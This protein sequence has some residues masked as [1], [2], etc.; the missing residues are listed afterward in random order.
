MSESND[1]KNDSW[2]D[3]E[4]G[5]GAYAFVIGVVVLIFLMA[6][7]LIG[8]VLLNQPE[9]QDVVFEGKQSASTAGETAETGETGEAETEETAPAAPPPLAVLPEVPFPPDNPYS[10]EKAE[11]GKILFFDPRFSGDGSISCNSCHPASDGSWTVGSPISFGY[12]GSTHW[13]NASTIIN[14]AYYTKV[15]WDGGKTSL[16]KQAAGAWGGAVAGNMDSALAEERMA[17]IPGY[18]DLF[19]EVFGTERP[20]WDQALL[21]VGTFERTIVSENV[22]FDAF[23]EGDES[24]ISDD[25][26]AGY[27]LFTGKANCIACHNGPLISDD[28]FHV[29]AVPEAPEFTESALNQITFRFEQW[30]KGVTEEDYNTATEDFGLYYVTKQESDRGA[31]HTMALRDVCYTAPYMHNGVFSTLEEVVT[32]Y[33][34][35]GGSSANKDPLLQPLDLTADEQAS[36]I[37]FL[38]SLCGDK[39][40]M[41]AP[42]LPEYAPWDMDGAVVSSR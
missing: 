8:Y 21:A 40:I 11:L 27:D 39:I 4:M 37:T 25:A 29:T 3:Q 24:A 15:N 5:K 7:G 41:D 10:E 19:E 34:D 33:N 16:E 17:L 30:A 31:F 26:K 9:K 14:S 22:P 32:F 36:L 23:L 12:P 38:N 42:E 13:R 1:N 20:T 2:G 28:S 18:V 6:G 35:G